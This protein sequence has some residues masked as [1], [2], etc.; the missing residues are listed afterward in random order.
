MSKAAEYNAA[1]QPLLANPAN[2]LSANNP[3]S[4]GQQYGGKM[5]WSIVFPD[6]ST[7]HW[8]GEQQTFD[9]TDKV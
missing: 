8:N 7:A 9:I 6:G 2:W 5:R 4:V 3:L 1:I